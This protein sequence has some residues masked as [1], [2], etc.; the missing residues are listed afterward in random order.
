MIFSFVRKH[1]IILQ[2]LGVI[3]IITFI[4]SIL[5]IPWL[6][7]HLPPDYFI[8]KKRNSPPDERTFYLL[9]KIFLVMLRN[10]FGAFL[11]LAGFAMLFLPGQGILTLLLGL[12]MLSFPGKQKL[13]RNFIQR[14]SVQN[15]LN[16]IR[17]KTNRQPFL[18]EN[19]DL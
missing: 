10:V 16:W 15:S 8:R 7:G 11:L 17:I 18:W 19:K 4:L 14:P 9:L 12:S 6:I 2:W 1:G 13:I 3:S 5:L